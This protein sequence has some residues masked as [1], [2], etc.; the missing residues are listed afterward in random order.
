MRALNRITGGLMALIMVFTLSAC[1]VNINGPANGDSGKAEEVTDDAAA[2]E[3]SGEAA[4]AQEEVE[5][6]GDVVILYTSDIHC[7]I[8]QGFGYAGLKQIRDTYEAQGYTTLLVDN[9]DAIQGEAVGTLSKGEAIID[10]MNAIG[11][12]V[13]IPGNHDFDYG[14]EQ[15]LDLTKKADFPYICCNFMHEGEPVFEPYIIKEAAGMK[16][17]F[18]GVTTPKTITSSTPAYFQDENGDFVYGFC[19]DATGRALYNMVQKA[20]DDARAEGADYVYIMGHVGLE[21]DCTP[22]TYADIIANTNGIDVFLDGH[23]HD[24]E[25]IV[26]KNKDGVDVPRSAVGYKFNAI[27]YSLISKDKGIVETNILDWSSKKSVPSVFGI[28]NEIGD[29]VGEELDKL[30]DELNEKVAGS[31]VFLTVND[32]EEK[33]EEGNPIRMVRRGETN[34]GDFCTDAYRIRLNTDVAI[35]NGGGIRAEINEGDITYGDIINVFPF[36]NQLCIVR[37]TGQQ[38][39]DALEW[40][41]RVVPEETG[42]FLQVSGMT[43]EIDMSV[44]SGCKADENGM[45]AGIDGERRVKN[46]MV[47][48]EALDPD[49]IYTL[50]GIEYTLLNNGD[51]FTAFDGAELVEDQIMLDNQ[52]LIDYILDTLNGEI[53]EE[54]ADPYGQGRIKIINDEKEGEN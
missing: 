50:A 12:D 54:Y 49:K 4:Q 3:D 41:A 29:K 1:N 31:K 23:S 53:G 44:A 43:Y 25:Q 47:G 40:G 21:A 27:G 18:V 42:A 28:Q 16:I 36:N 6:N 46:V 24:T 7:G 48:D 8:D 30:K 37:V 26:M 33:D 13:A 45:C 34:M 52:L 2:A 39:L 20:V 17:A 51:G 35:M 5:K 14:M 19:Q 32:P 10:L 15:F 22:W 38:L 11:Y 9:G